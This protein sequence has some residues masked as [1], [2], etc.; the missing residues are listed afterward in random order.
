MA[1]VFE[2]CVFSPEDLIPGPEETTWRCVG[3]DLRYYAGL[4]YGGHT[5]LAQRNRGEKQVRLAQASLD[6]QFRTPLI[7]QEKMLQLF[8]TGE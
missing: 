5:P 3:L 1:C 7:S 4:A 8:P 2:L 6:W